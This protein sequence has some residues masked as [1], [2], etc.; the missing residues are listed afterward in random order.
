MPE[1]R[2]GTLSALL[3]TPPPE[4]EFPLF[5]SGVVRSYH[6]DTKESDD[7]TYANPDALVTTDW[8]TDDRVLSNR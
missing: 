3:T 7:V 6:I 8:L 4:S 5:S 2:P 1:R